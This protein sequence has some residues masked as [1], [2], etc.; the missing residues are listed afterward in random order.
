MRGK[1]AC[2]IGRSSIVGKPLGQLLLARSATVFHCHSHTP[3]LEEITRQADFL[4]VA[5]GK[6]GLIKKE[7][8]KVGAVVIDVGISKDAAGKILGDV[9]Y[10]SVATVA[11][12]VT[13]VPGGIGPMTI[14]GLL[15]NTIMSAH[16]HG[17]KSV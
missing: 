17:E 10:D 16:R 1:I 5:V 2:V 9:D 12:A 15:E 11:S 3:H 4:F 14:L 7:H 13:P 8:I 6:A